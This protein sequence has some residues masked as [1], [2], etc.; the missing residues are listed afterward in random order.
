MK[1]LLDE[2]KEMLDIERDA[3]KEIA[4]RALEKCNLDTVALLWGMSVTGLEDPEEMGDRGRMTWL[5]GNYIFHRCDEDHEKFRELY[6][7]L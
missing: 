6:G 4:F 1:K 3:H 2:M 7:K 5:L